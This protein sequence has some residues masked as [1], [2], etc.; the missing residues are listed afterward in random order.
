MSIKPEDPKY[1]EFQR[2]RKSLIERLNDWE[3]QKS[4]DDFYRTYWRLIYGVAMK[5]GLR[6]EEARAGGAQKAVGRCHTLPFYIF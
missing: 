1:K 2:T 4:W 5:S 6:N 3:D